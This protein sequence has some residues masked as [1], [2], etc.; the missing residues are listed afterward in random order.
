MKMDTATLG[1][2]RDYD[3]EKVRKERKP[4]HVDTFK[5]K[6]FVVKCIHRARTGKVDTR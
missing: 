3:G 4:S 6:T 2:T 5:G 1:V